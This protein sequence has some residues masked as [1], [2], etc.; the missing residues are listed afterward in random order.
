MK[1]EALK[2]MTTEELRQKEKNTKHLL[3]LLAISIASLLYFVLQRFFTDAPFDLLLFIITLATIGGLL[4]LL[5]SWKAIREELG[6]R[7]S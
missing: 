6:S 5:S 3:L 7:D 4:S 1:K 2:E